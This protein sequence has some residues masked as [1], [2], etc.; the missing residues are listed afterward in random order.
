MFGTRPR[1]R[2]VRPGLWGAVSQQITVLRRAGYLAER[3]EG[4][5]RYYRA[6]KDALSKGKAIA[7]FLVTY[8]GGG[9]SH[10]PELLAQA[11]VTF[12]A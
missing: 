6:S 8:I 5:T 11:K 3:R 9:M 2:G 4:T 12:I 1:S 10:D 7:R